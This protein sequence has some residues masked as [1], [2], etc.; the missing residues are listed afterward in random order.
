MERWDLLGYG[1]VVDG[2]VSFALALLSAIEKVPWS[3]FNTTILLL[4]FSTSCD[5]RPR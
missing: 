3:L 1:H 5:G 2:E 4:S